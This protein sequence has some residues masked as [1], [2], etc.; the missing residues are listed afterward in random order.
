VRRPGRSGSTG[1]LAAWPSGVARAEGEGSAHGKM[2]LSVRG[3]VV[4]GLNVTVTPAS[5]T[6]VSKSFLTG[7]I[8]GTSSHW[9]RDSRDPDLLDYVDENVRN[10]L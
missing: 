3:R 4:V 1:G 7:C 6:A 8:I 10:R 5:V 2:R 9:D